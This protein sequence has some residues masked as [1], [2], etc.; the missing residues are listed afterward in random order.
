M[1]GPVIQIIKISHPSRGL[2]ACNSGYTKIT[3]W[4]I[5]TMECIKRTS[6]LNYQITSIVDYKGNEKNT[7]IIIGG[8]SIRFWNTNKM[9]VNLESELSSDHYE[10]LQLVTL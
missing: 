5:D 2:I 10:H 8:K 7:I 6:M 1:P 4:D 3:I 9:F